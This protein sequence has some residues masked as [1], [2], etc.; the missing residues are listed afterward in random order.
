MQSRP[1]VF[2][3]SNSIGNIGVEAFIIRF[4]DSKKMYATCPYDIVRGD[5]STVEMKTEQYHS[6]GN[7]FIE[8]VSNI[9]TGAIGGPFRALR[10]GVDKYIHYFV[11][12]KQFYCF[13]PEKLVARLHELD[14]FNKD[15]W[16]W[17][18]IPN[19]GYNT[20][21]VA[22]PIGLVSDLRERIVILHKD[23]SNG[24]KSN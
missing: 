3:E 7:I 23:F 22:I 9:N 8:T 12:D 15:K 17:K 6:R 10:D 20:V 24:N 11:K 5:G 14:V 2:K 18:T 4:P 19:K 16:D 21:G 13:T 1:H